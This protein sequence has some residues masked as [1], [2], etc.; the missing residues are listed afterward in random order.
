MRYVGR[1]LHPA[2]SG[3]QGYECRAK[4]DLKGKYLCYHVTV[5]MTD[6]GVEFIGLVVHLYTY[7]STHTVS[8]SEGYERNGSGVCLDDGQ[9]AAEGVPLQGGRGDA[10]LGVCPHTRPDMTM[11]LAFGKGT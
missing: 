8:Q 11:R 6:M 2:M 5:Y 3:E 7:S 9:T 4:M 10:L 1:T